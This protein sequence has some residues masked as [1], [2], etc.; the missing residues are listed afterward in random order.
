MGVYH[1]GGIHM[2]GIQEK[3]LESL[4]YHAIQQITADEEYQLISITKKVKNIDQLHF[5]EAAKY[6]KKDRIYWT[7]TADDFTITGAGNAVNIT[8]DKNRFRVTEKE[9]EKIQSKAIIHNED[10]VP[11]TGIVA[12]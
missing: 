2:I 6:M 7:S 1:F 5:F 11:G 10:N 8:A 12:L 3:E 4:L 9:W